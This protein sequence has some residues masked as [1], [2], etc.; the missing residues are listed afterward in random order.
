MPDIARIGGIALAAGD[1]LSAGTVGAA[2]RTLTLAASSESTG[3]VR[4]RS[5]GVVEGVRFAAVAGIARYAAGYAGALAVGGSGG[6]LPQ[7][8]PLPALVGGSL[9][10][11]GTFG[12]W[13]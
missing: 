6:A 7:R 8:P 3:P 10:L 9:P 4:R 11:A 13:I 12:G 5:T 2:L 1:E